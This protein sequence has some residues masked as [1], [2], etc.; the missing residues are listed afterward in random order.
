MPNRIIRES[1][2]TSP[3]VDAMSADEERFFLRLM[4]LVDDF[5]RFDARPSVIRGRAFPL[6]RDVSDESILAWLRR[7]VE[8]EVVSVYE[9][10]GKRFVWFLNWDTYQ[11][12]RAKE[13]KWPAPEEGRALSPDEVGGAGTHMIASAITRNQTTAPSVSREQPPA[14]VPVVVVGVGV[15][16]GVESRSATSPKSHDGAPPV[17][18]ALGDGPPSLPPVE[19]TAADAASEP[20]A[21]RKPRQPKM[22]LSGE[23]AAPRPPA[24]P[25]HPRIVSDM[26]RW[27]DRF[28]VMRHDA[29]ATVPFHVFAQAWRRRGIDELLESLD[30]LEGDQWAAGVGAKAHLSEQVIAKGVQLARNG[31]A[32][33]SHAEATLAI[34]RAMVGA[35]RDWTP[36]ED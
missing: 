28:R 32:P 5:G 29:K 9:A 19:Q 33:R 4:L 24:D 30:G 35:P 18:D 16:D 22:A 12:R 21:R 3:T 23:E 11:N 15:E 10:K 14:N 20:P 27:L 1:I 17:A 13:S 7:L 36:P 34:S 25:D 2:L 31:G 6:K 8:L 26:G